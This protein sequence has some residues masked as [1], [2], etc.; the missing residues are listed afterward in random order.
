MSNLSLILAE[1][2]LELVPKEIQNLADNV[3]RVLPKNCFYSRIDILLMHG[4]PKVI[5]V[6]L[7]E[8]SLYFNLEPES[9][10]MFAHELIE[11]FNNLT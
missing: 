6:E 4:K 1:S 10:K 5:E 7:I 8:P 2:S 3:I 11:Y 9:S